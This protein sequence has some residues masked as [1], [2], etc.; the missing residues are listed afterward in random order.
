MD[1]KGR[2]VRNE[3]LKNVLI[4]LWLGKIDA[5]VEYITQVSGNLGVF[6]RKAAFRALKSIFYRLKWRKS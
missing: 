5:V 3:A 2:E 1:M 6:R 4:F